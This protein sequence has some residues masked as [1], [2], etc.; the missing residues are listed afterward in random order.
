[1]SAAVKD[2]G[3]P[4]RPCG[5]PRTTMWGAPHDHVGRPAC[6]RWAAGAL[7]SS[8]RTSV[9]PRSMT[10]VVRASLCPGMWPC[11]VP[12]ALLWGACFL[13]RASNGRTVE[14]QR[15]DPALAPRC[16][17]AERSGP[18]L[19]LRAPP[20]RPRQQRRP[21]AVARPHL[22]RG[23]RTTVAHERAAVRRPAQ[24][25]AFARLTKNRFQRFTSAK[26]PALLVDCYFALYFSEILSSVQEARLA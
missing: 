14:R 6:P 26:P 3:R 5:A 10:P 20:A 25:A 16:R 13:D 11:G 22:A 21:A 8:A 17:R 19:S 18:G 1:M 24:P 7:Q 2:R 12:I 4:A 23:H 9:R 15:S